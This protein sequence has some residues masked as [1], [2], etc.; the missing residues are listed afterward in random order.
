MILFHF[1]YFGNFVVD[2]FSEVSWLVFFWLIYKK[3]FVTLKNI[4]IL[5]KV[6]ENWSF[7][8]EKGFWF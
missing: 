3:M 2:K 5:Y 6:C 4:F 7:D 8:F 1:D